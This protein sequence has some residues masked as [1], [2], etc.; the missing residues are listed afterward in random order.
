MITAQHELICLNGRTV[1]WLNHQLTVKDDS[2]L[3]LLCVQT[4]MHIAA[5][6]ASLQLLQLLMDHGGLASLHTPDKCG[7]TPLDIARQNRHHVALVEF[8]RLCARC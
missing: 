3:P 8:R 2:A 5:R 4:A 7:D 6:K 1:H